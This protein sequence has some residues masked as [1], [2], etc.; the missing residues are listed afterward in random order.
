MYSVKRASY[1]RLLSAIQTSRW[2]AS[3]RQ[4]DRQR[5]L[6]ERWAAAAAG[7]ER[8]AAGLLGAVGGSRLPGRLHGGAA[9]AVIA[10]VADGTLVVLRVLPAQHQRAHVRPSRETRVW[11]GLARLQC[12]LNSAFLLPN[13]FIE[14]ADKQHLESRYAKCVRSYVPILLL[15]IQLLNLTVF[16]IGLGL[17]S[18]CDTL[19]SQVTLATILYEYP[20]LTRC[21]RVLH[22]IFT[23]T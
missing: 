12:A 14:H 20:I 9:R 18:V 19:F 2:C 11:R 22:P 1:H 6:P 7:D 16:C 17:V 23:H 4:W 13:I 5:R 15:G 3:N 10:G 8:R 21:F